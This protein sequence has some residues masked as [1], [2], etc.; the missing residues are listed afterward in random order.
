MPAN[1]DISLGDVPALVVVGAGL[2]VSAPERISPVSVHRHV[3][4]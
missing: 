1:V 2:L 4:S 3:L